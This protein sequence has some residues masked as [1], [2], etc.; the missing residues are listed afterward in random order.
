MR[1]LEST[2]R[3]STSRSCTEAIYGS[4]DGVG[5]ASVRGF[6]EFLGCEVRHGSV[7]ELANVAVQRFGELVH[8]ETDAVI[9]DP[10]FLEVVGAD[11][12]GAIAGSDLGA[13]VLR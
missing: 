5:A 13:P 6:L 10:V 11:L 8:G 7:D 4:V 1:A 2:C 9:G 3:A 12:L